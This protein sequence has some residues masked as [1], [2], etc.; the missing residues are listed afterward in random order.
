MT[1]GQ[2]ITIS[3][4]LSFC[5][6]NPVESKNINLLF[7]EQII[8]MKHARFFITGFRDHVFSIVGLEILSRMKVS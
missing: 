4:V 3:F 8:S 6:Y 1:I 5:V 2:V 7:A